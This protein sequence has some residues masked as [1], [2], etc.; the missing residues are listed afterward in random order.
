MLCFSQIV[1]HSAL[2]NFKLPKYNANSYRAYTLAGA[3]G[4]YDN[5]GSF[6]VKDAVLS[7][8]SGD[9][10]QKLETTIR[11]NLAVFDL[12]KDYASGDSVIE[13]EDED[14]FLEG[15]GWELDMENKKIT[16]ESSGSIR[17]YQ[18]IEFD[19]SDVF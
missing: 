18:P 3:E 12:G 1:P 19:I 9:Q 11:T 10:E 7:V 17:F 13:I 4:I 15:K 8:Y 16:I 2:K 5:E 6:T 14:F